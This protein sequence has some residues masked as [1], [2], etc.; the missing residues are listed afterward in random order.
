MN[1]YA[2]PRSPRPRSGALRNRRDAARFKAGD[3]IVLAALALG[4]ATV[5]GLQLSRVDAST[6]AEAI[7]HCPSRCLEI[8]RAGAAPEYIALQT[9]AEAAS[10]AQPSHF[11]ERR[12]PAGVTVIEIAN[13]RARCHTSPGAQ[14]LCQRAGWL[15]TPG[16][17]AISL[18]NRL[19]LTV[20]DPAAP[21]DA[22]HF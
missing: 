3:A 19:R 5:A 11:I 6:D 12:G 17:T 21:Y 7:V 18:P 2:P 4:V 14:G 22:V 1:G 16:D 8:R 9:P 15:E 10:D 13:G 20:I